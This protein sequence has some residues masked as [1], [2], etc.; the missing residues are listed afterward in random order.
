MVGL[1]AGTH[2]A[3]VVLSGI[4][5]IA[6]ADAMSDA[7][8]IHLSEEARTGNT[9]RHIWE[10]TMMTFASK[11]LVAMSFAVSIWLLP[12]ATAVSVSIV[13]GLGLVTVLSLALAKV[14]GE[15]AWK[16]VGEHV[17]ITLVVVLATHAVGGWV[18]RSS[19]ALVAGSQ[20]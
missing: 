18:A 16:V 14:Q 10:A 4:L 9:T 11:F 19:A 8:G 12:I 20:F 13:W 2:S 1:H 6:I 5:T 17:I 3:T 7:L 15:P